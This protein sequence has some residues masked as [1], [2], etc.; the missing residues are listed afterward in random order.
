VS[1][2]P[3]VLPLRVA[4]APYE[5]LDS[6]LEALARRSQTTVTTLAAAFGW[7]VPGA[8]GSLVASI[9][10][11]VLRRIEYQAGLPPG[12]LDAAVLDRYLPL[13]AVRRPPPARLATSRLPAPRSPAPWPPPA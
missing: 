12:R 2:P 3:R 11:D 7:P 4:V 5:P 10:D 13:G 1:P 9:P 8:R 6:W